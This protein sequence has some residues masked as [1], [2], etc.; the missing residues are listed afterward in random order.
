MINSSVLYLFHFIF[1]QHPYLLYDSFYFDVTQQGNCI[2]DFFNLPFLEE[3]KSNRCPFFHKHRTMQ[4]CF[5]NNTFFP[6]S[7]HKDKQHSK[8]FLSAKFSS[9]PVP[10]GIA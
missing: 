5:H 6:H 9:S 4:F 7:R 3:T 2:Y 10:S 8:L 1:Y